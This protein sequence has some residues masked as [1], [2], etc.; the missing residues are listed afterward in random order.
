[1]RAGRGPYFVRKHATQHVNGGAWLDARIVDRANGPLGAAAVAARRASPRIFPTLHA[2]AGDVFW[3]IAQGAACILGMTAIVRSGAAIE[4]SLGDANVGIRGKTEI[5]ARVLEANV[6]E[7]TLGVRLAAG[8]VGRANRVAEVVAAV[9]QVV[10]ALLVCTAGV[11]QAASAHL[12]GASTFRQASLADLVPADL[13]NSRGQVQCDRR[14]R[15]ADGA[16]T[17]IRVGDANWRRSAAKLVRAGWAAVDSPL[18]P[19]QD[20]ARAVRR[21][22]PTAPRSSLD[23]HVIYSEGLGVATV[24][25]RR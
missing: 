22:A 5:A 16:G 24:D 1:M 17:A 25:R 14:A 19:I 23:A 10:A 11:A 18:V 6:V 7:R 9:E 8:G 15:A 3:R 2:L 20:A 13:L 12:V 4:A 21:S